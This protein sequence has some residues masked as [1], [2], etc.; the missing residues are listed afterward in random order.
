M[1]FKDCL[2]ILGFS[3]Q[4][5]LFFYTIY[6]IMI[7]VMFKSTKTVLDWYFFYHHHFVHVVFPVFCQ[8]AEVADRSDETNFLH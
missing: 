1:L 8:G 2:Y 6:I 5:K 4:V 3:Y 7:I